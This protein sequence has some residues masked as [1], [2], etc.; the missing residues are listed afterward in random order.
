MAPTL[1]ARQVY[2]TSNIGILEVQFNG[3]WGRVCDDG[4]NNN[5]AAVACRMLGFSSSRS[6]ALSGNF[7]STAHTSPPI[8]LDDLNCTGNE[9]TLALCQHSPF[10][11]HDCQHSEDVALFCN[12]SSTGGA[13][14]IAIRLVGGSDAMSGRVEVNINGIWGTV[15]DDDFTNIDAMVVCRQLGLPFN[16]ATAIGSSYF[17]AGSGPILLDD[18]NCQGTESSISRCLY[19]STHN[20]QHTED[21]GVRCS[22][23]SIKTNVNYKRH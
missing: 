6:V 4:F 3:T 10:F 1:T 5:S 22:T 7:Q 18:V 12:L 19:S 17:G 9:P 14:S 16:G 21:V 23:G 8:V 11:Q 20:C 2:G 15:C 13:P